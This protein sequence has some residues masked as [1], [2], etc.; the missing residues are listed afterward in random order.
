M[1]RQSDPSGTTV[2]PDAV[3][4]STA[5]FIRILPAKLPRFKPGEHRRDSIGCS[6]ASSAL[7]VLVRFGKL[8]TFP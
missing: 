3:P 1:R 7:V 6:N 4:R 5:E 8:G 2:P